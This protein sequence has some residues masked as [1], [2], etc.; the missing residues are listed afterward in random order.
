MSMAKQTPQ[1]LMGADGSL[2]YEA[3][4][5]QVG[6]V[7]VQ[8]DPV[9][10][11]IGLKGVGPAVIAQYPMGNPSGLSWLSETLNGMDIYKDFV[12]RPTMFF[13]PSASTSANLGTFANPYNTQAALQAILSGNVAG[14]V[15]GFKRG[16]TLRVTGANG[17]YLPS[18]Y[19]AAG[20]PLTMCPY[21]DAEALPIIT[22]GAVITTWV[23]E[24]AG[25]NIWKYT[26]A[27]E[28]DAWQSNVRLWKKTF[29][30]S[31]V[32]TLT[33]AGTST[34]NTGVLYIRPYA[35]ENPNLG[36]VEISVCDYSM[37]IIHANVAASGY[38]HIAGIDF[39]KARDTNLRFIAGTT[40]GITTC[41]DISI[42]GCR[43]SGAG[44]DKTVQ[45]NP[46]DNIDIG[47]VTDAKRITNLYIA[48]NYATD[49]LNNP[50]EI[51][52][53]SGAILERN[54]GTNSGGH[55]VAEL[56][57]SN[58]GAIVRYNIGSGSNTLGRL[59]TSFG[60]CAIWFNCVDCDTGSDETSAKS[61]NNTA[62]FNLLLN[63]QTR[64]FRLRAGAYASGMK[65]QHNTCYNDQSITNPGTTNAPQ[66]WYVS[67]TATNGC[68]D[69]SNNL[70]Y[71]KLGS[72]QSNHSTSLAY[73]NSV[74]GAGAAVPTGDYNLYMTNWA[75]TASSWHYGATN[76]ASFTAYKSALA[77]YGLDQNSLA[78]SSISDGTYT[79]ATLTAAS[80][81]F[82]E[83]TY[84]P[85]ASA[86]AGSTALTGI[87]TKYQ[88]GAPYVAASATIG[89]L[90]GT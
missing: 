83:T 19:G 42:V 90:L 59:Y 72:G 87:G 63:N 76:Q 22:G 53:T 49:A 45:N 41:D 64:N 74:L 37:R 82:S 5:R 31:A 54:I 30:V 21:G 27:T 68:I 36:Q 18:V 73:I 15:M 26:L 65:F 8:T 35:G 66:G 86:A 34:Y 48:G 67:G 2:G 28:S 13:D 12:K 75:G 44:V 4:G 62:I 60:Q 39:R 33:T 14:Q 29:S 11:V 58:S 69:I 24:D 25:A 47:C 50:Y 1:F 20:F 71:W 89:A 23:L 7:F 84:K 81:G 3:D 55:T 79:G 61:I 56:Y 70:F 40:S 43:L 52:G 9:T 6:L 16:T 88:D 38:I 78:G 32:A 17:L 10:G 46:C 57:A 51:N 85:L 80:L 77:A